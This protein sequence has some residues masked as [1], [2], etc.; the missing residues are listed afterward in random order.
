MARR[1]CL[2]S[3]PGSAQFWFIGGRKMSASSD[4]SKHGVLCSLTGVLGCG[5]RVSTRWKAWS[6][7]RPP[8]G[9]AGLRWELRRVI[10]DLGFTET[11]STHV[12]V[13]INDRWAEW[14]HPLDVLGMQPESSHLGRS[15]RALLAPRGTTDEMLE[16]AEQE[17]WCS[18]GMLVAILADRSLARRGSALRAR[19]SLLGSTCF[20]HCLPASAFQG[21][22]LCVVS[23][24]CCASCRC[25][26][27]IGGQCFHV[28]QLFAPQVLPDCAGMSTQG[29]VFKALQNMLLHRGVP[30]RRCLVLEARHHGVGGARW[31]RRRVGG[32]TLSGTSPRRLHARGW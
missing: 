30:C 19:I 31:Q 2:C 14:C 1:P 3:Q 12:S 11:R 23:Q 15:R 24:E 27:V 28:N 29:R 8:P 18:T 7:S 22:N 13:Y 9:G 17:Y 20:E 25:D 5:Q 32:G 21:L 26:P 10:P 6:P 16:G 4:P